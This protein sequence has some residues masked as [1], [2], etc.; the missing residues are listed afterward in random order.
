MLYI[1]LNREKHEKSSCLKPMIFGMWHHLVDYARGAKNGPALGGYIFYIDLYRENI[2]KSSR[3][4]HD[5][6]AFPLIYDAH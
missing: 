3:L 4:K 2:K 6:A 1:G 5:L